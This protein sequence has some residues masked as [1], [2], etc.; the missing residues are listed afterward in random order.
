M[1]GPMSLVYP[2]NGDTQDTWGVVLNALLQLVENHDH[3]SGKGEPITGAALS[4]DQDISWGQHAITAVTALE[5]AEVAASAVT[6]YSDALYVDSS[7]HNL[8]F[9]NQG[10]TDVKITDGNTLNV[11][12]VGGIGGDYSSVGALLSYDDATKRYLLQQE[13]S[14]KPWAGLAT[15]DIDL[16]QKAASITNKVTLKS[17]SSLAASYTVTLPTAVPAATSPIFL[18]SGGAAQYTRTETVIIPA[19]AGLGGATVVGGGAHVDTS[20]NNSDWAFPICLPAGAIITSYVV[21][22]NKV[23]NASLTLT[24]KLFLVTAGTTGGGSGSAGATNAANAPGAITLTE[25]GL[26]F[27]VSAGE[28]YWV[29]LSWGAAT[30]DHISS[31]EVTYTTAGG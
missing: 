28:V 31:C 16:Y 23:T 9:R 6:A 24:S 10:G 26:A 27:G 13:G 20:S 4:I 25:T 5:L 12:I 7:D 8:Y 2:V 15:G 14:P 29:D 19:I 11:S 30:G 17:P 3:T 22:V 1:S 21:H 18:T